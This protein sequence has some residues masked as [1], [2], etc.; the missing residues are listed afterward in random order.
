[1]LF[2]ASDAAKGERIQGAYVADDEADRLARFWRT[3]CESVGVLPT[4]WNMTTIAS[5]THNRH[6]YAKR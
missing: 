2:L 4:Q 5:D 3:Q 1:M 6:V